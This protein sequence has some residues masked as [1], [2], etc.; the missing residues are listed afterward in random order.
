MQF[1][2]SI[3]LLVFFL[4]SCASVHTANHYVDKNAKGYNN[5]TSWEDAWESFSYIEWNQIQPGDILYISGGTDSIT[6]NESLVVPIDGTAD[7][8]I[9]IRN[10]LDTLHNGKVILKGNGHASGTA[11]PLSGRSYLR[12]V[13]IS[14]RSWNSGM[15]TGNSNVIYWDSCSVNETR[16]SCSPAQNGSPSDSIFIWNCHLICDFT[17]HDQTDVLSGTGVTY[18][19]VKNCYLYQGNELAVTGHSDCMQILQSGKQIYYNNWIE[20]KYAGENGA[21][22]LPPYSR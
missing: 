20:S 16:W 9:T 12:I 14:M 3:Y 7:N 4:F 11:I 8:L 19:E 2:K 10:G 22:I 21:L 5:G 6:Y 1:Y 17:T 18:L 15:V 13:G